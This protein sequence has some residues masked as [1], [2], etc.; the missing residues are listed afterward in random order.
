[1]IRNGFVD[2]AEAYGL[3]ERAGLFPP[4]HGTTGGNL[5]F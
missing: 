1:M 2:E 4:R 3:L 5:P